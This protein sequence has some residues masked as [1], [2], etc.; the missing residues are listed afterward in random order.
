MNQN[1]TALLKSTDSTGVRQETAGTSST[2]ARD[3]RSRLAAALP[4]LMLLGFVAMLAAVLGKRLL[5]ATDLEIASVVTVRQSVDDAGPQGS[6]TA[7]PRDN[8]GQNV[9]M[10]ANVNWR[11]APM[12]F[13]ASGWVEPDPYPT[14]A[15][16]LVDGVIDTVEVLEGEKV[17][18]GQ[19]LATLIN[20]DATLDLATAKSQLAS[21]QG[22]AAGH[23]RMVGIL[24]A[25]IA[26]LEKQV[27]VAKARRDEA[28]DLVERF[29]NIPRGGVSE[30]EK[31]KAR[32]ELA[33]LQAEV[34]ALAATG[35]ELIA[36]IDQV[37]EVHAEHEAEIAGAET[38]V[39]RKQL[40][41]DRTRI[42]S[43][44]D[45]R[46]LRLLAAPGQK[47]MLNMDAK[48][49][50]TV[51]ILYDPQELQA[52]IDVPLAEAAQLAVGQPVRL[53]SELLPGKVF[54]GVVTRIVGEA[55]LQR[56]TL[57]AKV[58]IDN[59]DER[60]RPDMLCRAEFLAVPD[61]GA[62]ASAGDNAP[63]AAVPGSGR[64]Q[65]FV[66]VA[67]LTGANSDQVWK[68]DASGDH[69][70]LQMITTG[71][72]MRDGHRLVT[73]GLKPGDRVVLNPPSGLQPG[74]RFRATVNA[75]HSDNSTAPVDS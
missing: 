17:E 37:H 5:P 39:A 58:A 42:T 48:D 35:Q 65:I 4:W 66:P 14:L 24:E 56:N 70:E 2:K 55:D 18:R 32:L 61:S 72:E 27:E 47:K 30:R 57:Q 31:S 22:K 9:S 21:L 13:Q 8:E 60:L 25:R 74:E 44:I 52:R 54:A 38:E 26:S 51:A 15:T 40:M 28:A 23:Y 63:N 64:V 50:A 20:D 46:V 34:E 11:D 75:N 49:S 19:V 43:P 71:R 68:V 3:W 62:A 12:L 36:Q 10:A 33:T 53:R 67:A 1:L 73:D 6:A 41:L 16:A 29:E 45:G 59:P 69:V 7:A